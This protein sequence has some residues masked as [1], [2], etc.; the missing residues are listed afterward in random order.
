[1]SIDHQKDLVTVKG[2]IDVKALAEALKEKLKRPVEIVPAKK[3]GG[4]EKK[5]KSDGGGGG[6]EKAASAGGG[7]GDGGLKVEGNRMVQHGPQYEYG[8]PSMYGAGYISD[9]V[10]APQLFSDENPNACV[11]M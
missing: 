11:I 10:H 1:M 6:G 7:G 5:E 9:H 8:H 2:A 3:E 4:G